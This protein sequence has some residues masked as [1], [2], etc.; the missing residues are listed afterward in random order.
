MTPVNNK[1]Q[2]KIYQKKKVFHIIAHRIKWRF[3]R[4]KR[5]AIAKK[6]AKQKK[7]LYK[8]N[9]YADVQNERVSHWTV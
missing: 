2:H 5:E 3:D 9:A 6:A 7:N 8:V 4:K 1:N